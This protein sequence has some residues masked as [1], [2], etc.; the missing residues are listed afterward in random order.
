MEIKSV[1]LRRIMTDRPELS[2]RIIE[3]AEKLYFDRGIKS[4]SMDDVCQQL[5]ISKK[6]IYQVFKDKESL[7]KEVVFNH[8]EQIESEIS[9]IEGQESHPIKQLLI[10][11]EFAIEQLSKVNPV[12]NQDLKKYHPGIYQEMVST[13]GS[14]IENHLLKNI[15]F[16]RKLGCYRLNFNAEGISQAF[17]VLLYATTDAISRGESKFQPKIINDIIVYHLRG[18]ANEQGIQFLE[19]NHKHE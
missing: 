19:T 8:F 18:I 17:S 12:M 16:G 10:T 4:V 5:G 2:Q 7:V 6:T 1:I 11:A 14:F 3:T 13:R 9:R 15:E